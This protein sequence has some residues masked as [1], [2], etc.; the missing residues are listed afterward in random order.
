M[1]YG[2]MA[3][4]IKERHQ[5]LSPGGCKML[6]QGNDCECTL[7]LAD[8]LRMRIA[9]F[10]KREYKCRGALSTAIN[11]LERAVKGTWD[12]VAYVKNVRD[13]IIRAHDDLCIGA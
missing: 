13:G 9:E 10:E 11:E 12:G 1:D 8:N 2:E 7:C 5:K 6:S 4:K 3:E